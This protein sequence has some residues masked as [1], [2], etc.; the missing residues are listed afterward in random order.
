M[1]YNFMMESVKP[2]FVN[3]SKLNASSDADRKTTPHI[4][5]Y[6]EIYVNITG[7]VSFVIEKNIYSVQSGDIIVTKPYE[8]HHCVYHDDSDHLHFWIMFSVDENP[9]LYKFI[10][11]KKSGHRNLIR[12]SEDK[13]KKFLTH[14]EHL[15]GSSPENHVA[16][17]ATFFNILSYIEEGMEKYKVPNTNVSLPQ[18]LKTILDYINK[19]FASIHTINE[20]SEKFFISISTLE[21]HFKQYLS[22]TPK[23]YLEDKK[24]QHACLLLRENASVTDA[25]FESGFDDYSHFITIFKKKF[26]T[27]PLKYKKSMTTEK[28]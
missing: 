11:E 13:K 17:I 27:T 23:R 28:M 1:N 16:R 2:F 8:Y 24:L 18:S 26:D 4:H 22:M 7:N 6:C 12:L 25:C 15:A 19:N 14:C 9:E 21:R 10:T 3:V 20:I 5:E